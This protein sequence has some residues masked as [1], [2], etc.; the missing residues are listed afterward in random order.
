MALAVSTGDHPSFRVRKWAFESDTPGATRVGEHIHEGFAPTA[1]C[2]SPWAS[3]EVVFVLPGSGALTVCEIGASS[4]V[5]ELGQNIEV[6]AMTSGELHDRHVVVV[7]TACGQ[8]GIVDEAGGLI[9]VCET[10]H[11]RAICSLA[12]DDQQSRIVSTGIGEVF[13]WNLEVAEGMA[14]GVGCRRR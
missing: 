8:L 2:I 3:L 11:S 1:A 7:G 6:V 12:L 9:A 13:I 5:L 14:E 10:S 4:R